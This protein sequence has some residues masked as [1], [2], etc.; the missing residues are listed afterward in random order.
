MDKTKVLIV[1]DSALVRQ[2]LTHILE[3]DDSIEIVGTASDPYIARQKIKELDPDVLTLDVEMPRMDGVTFLENLMRLRP[4]PVVMVSSLTEKGADI[5]LRALET[6]A[7]DFVAKP[8]IDVQHGLMDYADLL[9]EKVKT[10]AGVGV[11]QLERRVTPPA[12]VPPRLSADAVVSAGGG[13]KHFRTTDRV[14]AIG[15]STGGTEAI[16]EVLTN[17]PPDAP[18]IV[19]S[20]HIPASF[21]KPF[22]E[23]VDLASPMHVKEA[24]DGDRIQPGH[25]YI[26]PGDRHLLVRRHGARYQIQLSDGPAVNRHRPSVDVMFRTVAQNVGPNAI[27]AILTGMGND[28]AQGLKEMQDAGA[29]TIAQNE[30]TCVVWGMPREA[31]ALGAADQVLPLGEVAN[32]LVDHVR[33]MKV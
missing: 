6:G 19:I 7:V 31:V 24:E 26:A 3:S 25:A 17:M 22:A 11:R 23:R 27:G 10:A 29:P 9:I 30:A 12:D 1:D 2:V 14:I 28:G 21:S 15:A 16:R 4:M 8:K 32:A 18:G 33:K 5:T 13:K 20:Q